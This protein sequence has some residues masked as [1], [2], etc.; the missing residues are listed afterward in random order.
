MLEI[1]GTKSS[2]LSFQEFPRGGEK[3]CGVMAWEEGAKCQDHQK[4]HKDRVA[5]LLLLL[6]E[7]C[8]MWSWT[9]KM[10][11]PGK[12]CKMVFGWSKS[13]TSSPSY[14]QKRGAAGCCKLTSKKRKTAAKM[15]TEIVFWVK[16]DILQPLPR[17]I[18]E[19]RE[20]S[21]GNGKSRNSDAKYEICVKNGSKW[22]PGAKIWPCS[23]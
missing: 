17:K 8:Q 16:Y 18:K 1:L 22:T 13:D 10:D 21:V 14:G 7:S 3:F 15:P 19:F 2:S 20:I 9:A 11:S 6:A 4:D 5:N 12:C 23:S